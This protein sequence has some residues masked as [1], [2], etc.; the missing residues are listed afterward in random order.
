MFS[1]ITL[2]QTRCFCGVAQ[3]GNFTIGGR[4]FGPVAVGGQP[5]RSGAGENPW[6]RNSWCAGAMASR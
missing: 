3:K 4:P 1:N 6:A 5:G 2:V